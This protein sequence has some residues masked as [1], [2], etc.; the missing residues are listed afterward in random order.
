MPQEV[1][2]TTSLSL[3]DALAATPVF[4]GISRDGIEWFAQHAEEL[5]LPDG[6]L[7]V[8]A[9]EPA[10]WMIVILEGEIHA[11]REDDLE[12][13]TIFI[14]RVGQVTGMLPYSRMKV[15]PS[16]VHASGNTRLARFP[17]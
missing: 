14:G 16:M 7:L 17:K 12:T 15:F 6:A 11:R 8:R 4:E 9:G 10:D 2:S 1:S 3:A 13:P 5:R